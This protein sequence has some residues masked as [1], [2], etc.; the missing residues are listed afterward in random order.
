MLSLGACLK[1]RVRVAGA[2][3]SKPRH[4]VR[5]FEPQS[6]RKRGTLR[7]GFEDSAPATHKTPFAGPNWTPRNGNTRHLPISLPRLRH[8]AAAAPHIPRSDAAIGSPRFGNPMP[9][10]FVRQFR[11]PVQVTERNTD[12]EIVVW[13][14]VKA[15]K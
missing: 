5:G 13:K 6:E 10:F 1:K 14:H 4:A 8:S 15:A 3:S 11:E 2:E 7:R 9:H 12:A